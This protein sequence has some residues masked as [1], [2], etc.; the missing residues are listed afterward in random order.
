MNN[1][2]VFMVRNDHNK[3]KSAKYIYVIKISLQIEHF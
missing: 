2:G 3:L 1:E